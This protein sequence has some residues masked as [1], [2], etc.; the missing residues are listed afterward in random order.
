M[1]KLGVTTF[2]PQ[3]DFSEDQRRAIRR[4]IKDVIRDDPEDV[5]RYD[6]CNI[7]CTNP[8]RRHYSKSRER[9]VY[10]RDYDVTRRRRTSVVP[11]ERTQNKSRT[12]STPSGGFETRK[13]SNWGGLGDD[14]SSNQKDVAAHAVYEDHVAIASD[15]L[16][17]PN[18]SSCLIAVGV[19]GHGTIIGMHL[20]FGTTEQELDALTKE[21]TRMRQGAP[22]TRCYLLG[23]VGQW[24][25]SKA[26]TSKDTTITR[27]ISGALGWPDNKTLKV[28]DQDGSWARRKLGGVRAHYVAVLTGGAVEFS[29]GKDDDRDSKFVVPKSAFIEG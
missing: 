5:V 23:V 25:G 13:W 22:L 21:A 28:L 9:Y 7:V 29:V 14:K 12:S 15:F 3:G 11:A 20:T 24:A 19:A 27:R 18:V 1:A 2:Y 6:S 26:L 16:T 10:V 8:R 17:F 4:H